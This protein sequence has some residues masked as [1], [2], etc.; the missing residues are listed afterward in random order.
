MYI[1]YKQSKM[2]QIKFWA[3]WSMSRLFGQCVSC[4]DNYS[5]IS[6]NF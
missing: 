6:R 5:W 1:N 4:Q 3:M 2:P